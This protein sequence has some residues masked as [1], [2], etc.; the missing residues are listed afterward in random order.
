MGSS[1]S[2][3]I[4]AG[5][6]D[7]QYGRRTLHSLPHHQLKRPPCATATR[8][9]NPLTTFRPAAVPE[10]G[11]CNSRSGDSGAHM[12]H[13]D[14]LGERRARQFT[15]LCKGHLAADGTPRRLAPLSKAQS[16]A[17]SCTY[18]SHRLIPVS[19]LD[20]QIWS[21][22]VQTHDVPMFVLACARTTYQSPN[23]QRVF[24]CEA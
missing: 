7:H 20:A 4:G 14:I 5:H 11:E 3:E 23:K 12:A 15:T 6:R 18:H 10:P 21:G 24:T 9:L 17:T 8:P 19:R 1:F 16:C 13:R 2:V 22:F